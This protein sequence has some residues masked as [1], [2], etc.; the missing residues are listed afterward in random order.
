MNTSD[1]KDESGINVSFEKLDDTFVSIYLKNA[2][3]ITSKNIT[4]PEKLIDIKVID[5]HENNNKKINFI[6]NNI[7]EQINL[8]QFFKN[9]N[10][11][12]AKHLVSENK[13][14]EYKDIKKKINLEIESMILNASNNSIQEK[15]KNYYTKMSK[16]TK[17]NFK[18]F[19]IS[20]EI[21]F[22]KDDTEANSILQKINE[23]FLHCPE[24]TKNEFEKIVKIFEN[25][26]QEAMKQFFE[27]YK[28]IRVTKIIRS[29]K[30]KESQ[31]KQSDTIVKKKSSKINCRNSQKDYD[32]ND[33][34]IYGF[35][36]N[37]I[38]FCNT[39]NKY[40]FSD[41]HFAH[42]FAIR[43]K[44][45]YFK[46][47]KPPIFDLES[48][49]KKKFKNFKIE[50]NY[51]IINESTELL[52]ESRM[53]NF[54]YFFKLSKSLSH[55]YNFKPLKETDLN[56]VLC[57]I[58][59]NNLLSVRIVIPQCLFYSD[60]MKVFELKGEK[61]FIN[62][63]LSHIYFLSIFELFLKIDWNQFIQYLSVSIIIA[64]HKFL[65]IQGSNQLFLCI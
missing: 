9:F 58:I 25:K 41:D 11:Y 61:N 40:K 12:Y 56:R 65:K 53:F 29:L 50:F 32:I 27:F 2:K 59:E 26:E 38:K 22:E 42:F 36:S 16:R 3:S 45:K 52:L 57:N 28:K 35:C 23:Y 31:I 24:D 14:K 64:R 5:I 18:K 13:A 55:L 44:I 17:Y 60:Y 19:K 62:D 49:V 37:K 30:K 4:K 47:F 6:N 10:N 48:F 15:N 54:D 34:A 46:D 21:I 33:N 1:L 43:Y 63:Y 51:L 7:L 8:N 20:D 39:S